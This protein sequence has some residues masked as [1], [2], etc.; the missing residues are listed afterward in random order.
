M[1]LF[2]M[3]Y[4][5]L[6]YLVLFAALANAVCIMLFLPLTFE[7]DFCFHALPYV[8]VTVCLFKILFFIIHSALNLLVYLILCSCRYYERAMCSP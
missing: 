6:A 7:N 8:I 4:I 3:L 2:I 1:L 5:I